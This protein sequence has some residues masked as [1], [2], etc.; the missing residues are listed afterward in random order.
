MEIDELHTRVLAGSLQAAAEICEVLLRDLRPRVSAALFRADAHLV[1]ASIEDAVLMYLDAP[2]R[3][4]HAR[5]SLPNWLA[6]CAINRARNGQRSERCRL[7][8]EVPMGVDLT[9][10]LPGGAREGT[11]VDPEHW[12]RGHRRA[13]L[14]AARTDQERA[15]LAAR[16]D[17]ASLEIQVAALGL[18]DTPR[19]QV[20]IETNRVWDL[21]RRRF[22]WRRDHRGR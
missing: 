14:A 15:F 7:A 20:R 17:G 11:D 4:D 6:S 10:V 1:D 22:R 13:L 18:V 9:A 21:I 5:G 12:V 16:L 3:Y 2:S 19:A 8:H